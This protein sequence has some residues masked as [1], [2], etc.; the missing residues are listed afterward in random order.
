MKQNQGGVAGAVRELLVDTVTEMG[1]YLWDVAYVKEG[2]GYYLRITIDS[3]DGINID[4]CEKVHRAIDPILDRADPIDQAYTLEVS[5]P[6]IE[7]ELRTDEHLMACEDW[8]V[9][10]RLYAPVDGSKVYRG[11]LR[12]YLPEEGVI[13]LTLPDGSERGFARETVSKIAT[14]YD[15]GD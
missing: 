14:V 1:Y 2:A 8:Q 6:G 4:D 11:T 9:E 3:E 12:E 5:S 10:V 7:R 15:F 13:Y